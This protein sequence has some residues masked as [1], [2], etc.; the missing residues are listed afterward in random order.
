MMFRKFIT[1]GMNNSMRM[2]VGEKLNNNRLIKFLL[3]ILLF[4]GMFALWFYV[5][6]YQIETFPKGLHIDEVGM[7][8]DAF[9]LAHWGVDRTLLSYPV[10]SV[11]TAGASSVLYLYCCA[12]FFKVFSPLTS[13]WIIRLPAMLFSFVAMCAIVASVKRMYSLYWGILSGY[14]Y[15]IFPYFI[16]KS[17]FGLDCNLLVDLLMISV[18]FTIVT[19]Q[20]GRKRDYFF[21][22]VSYGITLYTYAI[23]YIMVPIILLLLLLL[24]LYFKVGTIRKNMLAVVPMMLLAIPLLIFNI[25]NIFDLSTVKLFNLITIPHMVNYRSN[26]ITFQ[27]PLRNLWNALTVSVT[28]DQ[29]NYNCHPFT[30][31]MYE[32]SIGLIILGGIICIC[33][34]VKGVRKREFPLESVP[35]IVFISSCIFA[36]TNDSININRI[37]GIFCSYIFFIVISIRWITLVANEILVKFLHGK[38]RMEWIRLCAA[39]PMIIILFSYSSKFNSF[40]KIYYAPGSSYVYFDERIDDVINEMNFEQHSDEYYIQSYYLYYLL[41]RG[42]NPYTLNL[43]IDEDVNRIGNLHFTTVTTPLEACL[44]QY[45]GYVIYNKPEFVDLL[46]SSGQFEF[47]RKFDQTNFVYLEKK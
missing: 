4:A 31:T 13:T 23:S 17:R 19:V 2:I 14:L 37:N 38:I 3:S 7:A 22:G 32:L 43:Q 47:V 34:L 26:E 10:Y 40:I 27:N 5:H 12:F 39:I 18:Y 29:L 8:Y 46:M 11:N 35:F 16:M 6:V 25:I 24:M 15:C 42:I 41:A 9:C 44:N 33:K 30:T 45:K 21:A 36:M 1:T 20:R 28:Q